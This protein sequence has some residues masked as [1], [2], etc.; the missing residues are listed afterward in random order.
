MKVTEFGYKVKGVIDFYADKEVL[1]LCFDAIAHKLNSTIMM[2]HGVDRE[3]IAQT[4]EALALLA[5][6][7]GKL[8]EEEEYDRLE[9]L[10]N[11]ED[12]EGN[13]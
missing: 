6:L 5:K 9:K 10:Q 13:R 8:E 3:R 12:S 1:S 11:E 7:I 2:G 4:A